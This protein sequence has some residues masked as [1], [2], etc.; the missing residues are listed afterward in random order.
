MLINMKTQTEIQELSLKLANLKDKEYLRITLMSIG[1]GV[2][3]T[4]LKGVITNINPVASTM[5]G[6]TPKEAIGKR[7]DEVLNIVNKFSRDIAESPIDLVIKH[8]IVVGLANHTVLISKDEREYDIADSGAPIADENGILF[9]VVVVFRDVTKEYARRE[10]LDRTQLLLKASLESPSGII[11]LSLDTEYKYMFYNETHRADMKAAYGVDVGLG[12][13][14]FDFMTSKDDIDR[15]KKNFDKALAGETH[16]TLEQF[17]VDEINY[18]ENVFSPIKNDAQEIIG[19]SSFAR[20]VSERE[21]S[22]NELRYEKELAQQYLDLAGTIIVVLNT[23][24]N[25]SL[26]NQK[27]CNIIG[28]DEEDIVGKNWFDNFIP[29]KI[30]N[31]VKEVFN[32]ILSGKTEMTKHYENILITSKKEERIVS[33]DNNVLRDAKGIITGAIS[34]GEDITDKVKKQTRLLE[35]YDLL[36]TTQKMAK[37]G[38]WEL[39]IATNSVWASK[40]AFNIYDLPRDSE[41]IDLSKTQKMIVPENRE[42]AIEGLMNLIQNGEPYDEYYKI[43]TGTKIKHIH[44]EAYVTKNSLG[45][46]IKVLGFVRDVTELKKKEDALILAGN[47]F[48]NSIENAPLPIMIHSEDGTVLN[49]S[50]NWTKLTQYTKSDIPTIFDWTEKAYGQNKAEVVD[51]I[52]KLYKLTEIQH[53]GEFVVTTKDGRKLTWDFNSGYIGKLPDGRAVAMSV[54]TDV[55]ERITKEQELKESEEKYR[56]L[57]TSMNQGLA[58]HEIILDDNGVPV[59][60]TYLDINDS[61]TTLFDVTR[62]MSIGKRITEVMPLVEPYWIQTFGKV[63]L[64]G[65]PLYYENYL[66]TTKRHYSTYSYSPK[67]GQFAVLVSDITDRINREKEINYLSYHDQLTGLYNRRFFEEQMKRLDNP[68][69]LPFSIIMGDVNGLKLI[70][71]AFGHKAG[72]ELISLVGDI[73]SKSIRGNDIASRWGGDEFTILLPNSDSK[74][75]EI[76]IKRIQKS[77]KK[78]AFEYGKISISFGVDTKRDKEEDINKIFTSAEALMYQN[79]LLEIDSIRGETINTIMTTLFEKSIEVKDHSMRVSKL[80]AL[81]AEKMGLSKTSIND[82]KTMGMI[83]DIGKIVIDLQILDK[84]GK[85]TDEERNIIK[86]HPLSGSRMLNSSHEYTR[87]AAGVLHHHERIDGKGYPNGITG[88]QIPIE[89]KIIAVADAYDAMT[90]KRPYRLTPLSTIEAIAE[91]QKYSG[92]QFDKEV[93]DV[94]VNKVLVNNQ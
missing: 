17:G 42:I 64:T 11:I 20:D 30:V 83:H 2:I 92:T 9:G 88:D 75:A 60:Y 12:K 53:D 82:I 4:D 79:K 65:E 24:G 80:S 14:I 22:V 35:S 36:D 77:I 69:N 37:V 7:S 54:A 49:I 6:F 28:M 40:E 48:E 86:Q 31:D 71:D 91:L 68:R 52:K 38:T 76:L 3:T 46:P 1:D 34:S 51:F 33:W 10:E 23:E 29:K 55:T 93:V 50:H 5:T 56:L 73:L 58:L 90:A 44:A 15:V 47:I 89:S 32:S 25:V 18:Y 26:I 61:Y 45:E 41:Y 87:L 70:N 84:P 63:A 59:D 62:E 74:D 16:T 39:N 21:N 78:T 66:E 85:L 72:D 19:V 67:K 43:N 13:C 27:G 8:G 57:Y 81:L 94:F